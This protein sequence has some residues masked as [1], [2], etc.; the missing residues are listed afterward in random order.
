ML[1]PTGPSTPPMD[2]FEQRQ[3]ALEHTLAS[4][5]LLSEDFESEDG[6]EL[7]HRPTRR[8]SSRGRQCS[9]PTPTAERET[10]TFSAAKARLDAVA[11][12]GGAWVAVEQT[13]ETGLFTEEIDVVLH[14]ENASSRLGLRLALYAVDDDHPRVQHVVPGGL[15]DQSGQLQ[16]MD[17]VVAINGVRI[18]SD[19]QALALIVDAQG[20]VALSVRR[21]ANRPEPSARTPCEYLLRVDATRAEEAEPPRRLSFLEAAAQ[22]AADVAA[23]PGKE[24]ERYVPARAAQLET[25]EEEEELRAAEV[26][27]V[28]ARRGAFGQRTESP[29]DHFAQG[30]GGLATEAQKHSSRL[31]GKAASSWRL[32]SDFSAFSPISTPVMVASALL[33]DA[34]ESFT[35]SEPLPAS[36]APWRQQGVDVLGA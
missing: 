24:A 19:K 15:A 5:G 3:R 14:K 9:S 17:I 35:S 34:M 25:E 36:A 32:C 7:A 23:R 22:R 29:F 10:S 27:Y 8:R 26:V 4:S 21:D 13:A 1:S 33:D 11:A 16:S 6:D 31:C 12:E 30:V 2:A 18:S 28:E 20:D